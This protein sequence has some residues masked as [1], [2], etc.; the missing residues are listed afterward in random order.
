MGRNRSV[1]PDPFDPRGHWIIRT[2]DQRLIAVRI[3]ENHRGAVLP[4][5]PL[6]HLPAF[7][8]LSLPTR[9]GGSVAC[10]E[11]PPEASSRGVAALPLPDGGDRE[12]GRPEADDTAA[13]TAGTRRDPAVLA[14]S[15][16]SG[17]IG[18][19]IDANS[20]RSIRARASTALPVAVSMNNCAA[21]AVVT[22]E[23]SPLA[24]NTL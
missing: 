22:D 3:H 4:G 7:C 17:R 6:T 5:G 10:A 2:V 9:W 11:G 18:Q 8:R 13:S 1:T 16:G 14:G 24:A 19:S 15:L 21:S 23:R 12:T 20:E